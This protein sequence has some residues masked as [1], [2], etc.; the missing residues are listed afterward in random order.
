MEASLPA[1][2]QA[3]C[4]LSK[5]KNGFS[6]AADPRL[7]QLLPL[8]LPI[9]Q[10][11]ITSSS[12]M[13]NAY[14]VEDSDDQEGYEEEEDSVSRKRSC[15][16]IP[17]LLNPIDNEDA[18]SKTILTATAES[19]YSFT[20][21]PFSSP[22]SATMSGSKQYNCTL[23]QKKFMRPSS[24]KI[25]IYSHTGEKPFHCSFPGCRRRFSVQSNMRRHLR[26]H[27]N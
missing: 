23:C 20:A 1:Q 8:P 27:S 25:H 17:L 26:V 15:P 13:S 6:P 14:S 7:K 19:H 22:S 4:L 18:N 5:E 10:A 16:L 2:L 11:S 24:L 21:S 9:R 12:P 3:L